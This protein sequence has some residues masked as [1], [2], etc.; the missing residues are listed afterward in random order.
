MMKGVLGVGR[1]NYLNAMTLC[2]SLQ[3]KSDMSVEGVLDFSDKTVLIFELLIGR[4]SGLK[5]E[6]VKHAILLGRTGP[7]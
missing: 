5:L 6:T 3:C 7:K 2:W 4:D 1:T